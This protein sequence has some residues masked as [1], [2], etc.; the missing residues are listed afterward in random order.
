[1]TRREQLLSIATKARFFIHEFHDRPGKSSDKGVLEALL[2]QTECFMNLV[3][4]AAQE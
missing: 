4:A 2:F 3:E 1:M